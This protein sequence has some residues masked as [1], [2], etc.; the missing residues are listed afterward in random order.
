M[1]LNKKALIYIIFTLYCAALLYVLFIR[2]ADGLGVSLASIGKRLKTDVNFVPL[3]TLKS[4]HIAYN[5]GNLSRTTYVANIYGNTL[6]FVPMGIL[7]PRITEKLRS[8]I[9]FFALMLTVICAVELL[10]LMYGV[11]RADVDDVILNVL[12]A[13]AGWVLFYPRRSA[14]E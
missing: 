8:L 14:L 7:L 13:V 10:Q 11:G 5:A 9:R 1:N 3:Q 2:E 6:L 4:Y 12:G